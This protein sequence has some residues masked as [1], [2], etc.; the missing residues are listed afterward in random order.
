MPA[1]MAARRASKLASII[2]GEHKLSRRQRFESTEANRHR[3]AIIAEAIFTLAS[4]H[5]VNVDCFVQYDIDAC[6]RWPGDN[7]S[8]A[9]I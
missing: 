6:A 1:L 5:N 2:S 3:H 9:A 4:R 7:P 8:P